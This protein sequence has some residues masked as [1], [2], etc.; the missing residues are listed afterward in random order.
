[1]TTA[2][3]VRHLP[4]LDIATTFTQ[5]VA[6][7]VVMA[8]TLSRP[9]P[10]DDDPRAV[11]LSDDVASVRHLVDRLVSRFARPGRAPGDPS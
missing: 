11:T 8:L 10:D 4:W 2:D 7:A 3:E 1:M 6:I 5:V 9:T